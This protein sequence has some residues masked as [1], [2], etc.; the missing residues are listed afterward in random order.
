[1]TF[2]NLEKYVY[3]KKSAPRKLLDLLNQKR[4]G[5]Y[6]DPLIVHGQTGIPFQKTWDVYLIM[7]LKFHS[8][9]IL[10]LNKFA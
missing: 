5:V 10:N 7:L 1:M 4:T 3:S 8:L 9:Q 2:T 6:L